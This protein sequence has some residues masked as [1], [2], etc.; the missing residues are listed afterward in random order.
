[1]YGRVD[2]PGWGGGAGGPRPRLSSAAMYG[3]FDPRGW[4]AALAALTPSGRARVPGSWAL[5]DFANTIFSYAIVST[6]MGIW[7]TDPSR[8]GPA[9]GRRALRPAAAP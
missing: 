5:Y 2:P 3:R 4:A 1:M 6:A 8:P 7:L 9:G